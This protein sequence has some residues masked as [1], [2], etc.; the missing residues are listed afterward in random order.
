MGEWGWVALGF[1]VAYGAVA[2]YLAWLNQRI[3]AARRRLE[4]PR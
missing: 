2:A 4:E 1:T 3:R